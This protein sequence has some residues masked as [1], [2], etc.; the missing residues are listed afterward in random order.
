MSFEVPLDI[1]ALRRND[2]ALYPTLKYRDYPDIHRARDPKTGK[3]FR[4]SRGT[5]FHDSHGSEEFGGGH[6]DCL[7]FINSD[8]MHGPEHVEHADVLALGCSITSGMGLP[9]DFT[10]PDILR[11]AH[12]IKVNNIARPGSS[13]SQQV[14]RAFAHIYKYGKPKQISFLMPD[15]YRGQI[16]TGPDKWIQR[17][18][19]YDQ[20]EN[21]VV[22]SNGGPYIHKTLSGHKT[23]IPVDVLI[24]NNLKSLEMLLM[25]CAS[26][27]IK[28][29]LFTWHTFTLEALKAIGYP[30]IVEIPEFLV[31]GVEH[32]TSA[33]FENSE[34]EMLK[35]WSYPEQLK[36]MGRP[37]CCDLRPNGYWQEKAWTVALDRTETWRRPHPGLHSQIHFAEIMSGTAINADAVASIR[38]WHEGTDLEPDRT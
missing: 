28:L 26:N 10:W 27:S 35:F 15:L 4:W 25:F 29:R 22:D 24:D 5:L 33:L 2:T 6:K 30:E 12:G 38:P 13:V 11:R 21:V 1:A 31:A 18:V 34:T 9:Y 8:G 20:V 37:E 19:F 32:H 17:T 3:R 7:Y 16:S 36:G 14:Y 23:L